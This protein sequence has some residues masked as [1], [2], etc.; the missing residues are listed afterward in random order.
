MK[1]D[2]SIERSFSR[3]DSILVCKEFISRKV[4]IV[5]V[6]DGCKL[7]QLSIPSLDFRIIDS[8]RYV[9]AV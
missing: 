9:A 3:F 7:L 5:P 1:R 2:L 6:F 8:F 4:K